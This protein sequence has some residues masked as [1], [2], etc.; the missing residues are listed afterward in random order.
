MIPSVLT[1]FTNKT[2]VLSYSYSLPIRVYVCVCVC[3]SLCWVSELSIRLFLFVDEL[4]NFDLLSAS[5]CK[6]K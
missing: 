3:V 4:F 2:S 1:S 6:V 5:V